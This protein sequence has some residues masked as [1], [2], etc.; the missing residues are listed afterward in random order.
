MPEPKDD[1]IELLHEDFLNDYLPSNFPKD[2]EELCRIPPLDEIKNNEDLMTAVR[3][4][5]GQIVCKHRKR[6]TDDPN[7]F[8]RIEQCV[9]AAESAENALKEVLDL[10]VGM[11]N[12][13]REAALDLA[14]EIGPCI[15]PEQKLGN[16]LEQL[17]AA[18]MKMEI[19][20]RAVSTV[21]GVAAQKRG[22]GRP[23]SNYI[24]PAYELMQEWE[25]ITATPMT[26]GDALI[27]FSDETTPTE[28]RTLRRFDAPFPARK[29]KPVPTPRPLG[30]GTDRNPKPQYAEHSTAFIGQCLKMIAPKITPQ[31]VVTAIKHAVSLRPVYRRMVE[32]VH[33][34]KSRVVALTEAI[35]DEK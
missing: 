21:T 6:F 28:R 8:V 15:F 29:I 2:F 31:E 26:V 16:F 34:G 7:Y 18:A 30:K 17:A 1:E 35:R 33:A 12:E 5:L 23:L 9:R 32:N 20:E 11:D 19:L 24:V 22:K 14:R 13:H 27:G 4:D 25:I 10:F 3:I